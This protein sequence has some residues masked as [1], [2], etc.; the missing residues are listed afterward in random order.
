MIPRN[1][2]NQNLNSLTKQLRKNV[3]FGERDRDN[4]ERKGYKKRGDT[5]SFINKSTGYIT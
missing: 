5:F 4:T 1:S 2:D 3:W